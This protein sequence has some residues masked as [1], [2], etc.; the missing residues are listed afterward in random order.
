M[1]SDGGDPDGG[2]PDAG[3]LDGGEADGGEPDG[4]DSDGGAEGPIWDAGIL[5]GSVASL[6]D[7]SARNLPPVSPAPEVA[8]LFEDNFQQPVARVEKT[9]AQ[10]ARQPLYVVRTIF[11]LLFLVVLAYL[12]GHPRVQR[13]ERTLRISQVVTAGLPFLLLGAIASTPGIDIITPDVLGQISPVLRLGLGLIGFA[14]GFRFDVRFMSKLP[15]GAL[16]IVLFG[17]LL[18][19]TAIVTV[20]GLVLLGTTGYSDATLRDPVFLRDAIILGCAGAMT[21]GT[22]TLFLPRN[23]ELQAAVVRVVKIVR[24][25]ELFGLAGL[26]IVGAFFRPQGSAVTWQ[27]PGTA[28]L[29]L[30]FGLGTVV[31]VIVYGILLRRYSGPEFVVLTLGSVTFAAG[32]SGYL[33]LSSV[34]VCFF[35]GVLLVNFPGQYKEPLKFV[36]RKIERPVY[37][38][39]LVVV[40]ALFHASSWVGLLLLVVFVPMRLLGKWFGNQ[41]AL[42]SGR[43]DMGPEERK[44]LVIAPIG[45]LAIAI[46]VNAQ[47]LYPGGSIANIMT[48]VVGGAL[49]TEGLLQVLFR[50]T[51]RAATAAEGGDGAQPENGERE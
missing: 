39:F 34:V 14:I 18:P 49:L 47:L 43:L 32:L 36:L 27:L 28:W 16:S 3:D 30:T 37:L 22:A 38:L 11:G 33:L 1:L 40:G 46:V 17:T 24:L 7:Q 19:F 12:A 31:G 51:P 23:A 25:E 20:S 41:L 10:S 6:L 13:V 48:A 29:L 9:E 21:A 2:D 42:R 44:A 15:E 8:P 50:V 5:D 26:A 35:V 4:G 45:P